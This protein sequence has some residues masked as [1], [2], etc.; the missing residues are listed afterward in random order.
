MNEEKLTTWKGS[1]LTSS[2]V[3]RWMKF[4]R[5][6]EAGPFRIG[7]ES[8]TADTLMDHAVETA[9]T[10]GTAYKGQANAEKYIRAI[11]QRSI[12]EETPPG[13][14]GTIERMPVNPFGKGRTRAMD[15]SQPKTMA[16]RLLLGMAERWPMAKWSVSDRDDYSKLFRNRPE[17]VCEE[18]IMLVRESYSSHRP[19]YKWFVD[20]IRTIETS[21]KRET[22]RPSDQTY[23]QEQQICNAGWCAYAR[24]QISNHLPLAAR[25]LTARCAT[26]EHA[27]RWSNRP[28][29]EWPDWLAMSVYRAM[30][31]MGHGGEKWWVTEQN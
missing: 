17:E 16:D 23:A 30:C 7:T 13:E 25:A 3:A 5:S 21:R 22:E 1:D 12:A 19:S 11:C 18:A 6:I 4:S 10:N 9:I 29:H 20:A 15:V 26:L 31:S 24:D 14:F 28:V 2:E 8:W 27:M